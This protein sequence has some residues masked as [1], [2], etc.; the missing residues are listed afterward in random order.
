MTL[1]A[2]EPLNHQDAL[3]CLAILAASKAGS[4]NEVPVGAVLSSPSGHILSESA[5]K[6]LMNNNPMGHAEMRAM[7]QSASRIGNYRLSGCH[8]V[9]SLQPCPMCLGA[10]EAARLSQWTFLAER[11]RN[12]LPHY[13][14][15]TTAS[16]TEKFK[17]SHQDSSIFSLWSVAMLRF[18]FEQRR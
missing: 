3:N 18:F 1:D 15:K 5:N 12:D 16:A 9:A 4:R 6:I 8:L 11:P 2:I 7:A 14:C 10:M 17:S 13:H